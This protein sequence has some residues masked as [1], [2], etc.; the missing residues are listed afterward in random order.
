MSEENEN[1]FT[2]TI[3]GQEHKFSELSDENKQLVSHVKDLENQIDQ[4]NFRY[5]Q[6]SASKLFFSDKLI[7][8]INEK[9]D[10]EERAAKALEAKK[11]ADKAAADL[12][13][14]NKAI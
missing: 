11:K 2:I 13:A 6:L 4:L 7:E 8:S 1:D 14:K 5:E 12:S 9:K 3:E 10:A